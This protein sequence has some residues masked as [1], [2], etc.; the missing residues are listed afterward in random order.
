MLLLEYVVK[1]FLSYHY[2]GPYHPMEVV[3]KYRKAARI[4]FLKSEH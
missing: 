1:Y 2:H 4:L 3:V